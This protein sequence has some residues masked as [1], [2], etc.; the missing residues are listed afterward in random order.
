MEAS[1]NEL[2][3]TGGKKPQDPSKE[4]LSKPATGPKALRS[5]P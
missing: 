3:T 4:L 1:N 2:K 5:E